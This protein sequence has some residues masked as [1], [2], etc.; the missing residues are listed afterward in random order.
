MIS[1][2]GVFLFG[3]AVTLSIMNIIEERRQRKRDEEFEMLR[4]KHNQ[5]V[6][7]WFDKLDEEVEK[8]LRE[9]EGTPG[10]KYAVNPLPYFENLIGEPIEKEPAEDVMKRMEKASKEVSDSGISD[11]YLGR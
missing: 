7:K 5:M 9:Q 2:I 10:S 11:E 3:C 8:E 1:I 6:N 4:W